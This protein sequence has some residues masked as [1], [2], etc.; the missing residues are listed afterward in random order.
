MQSLKLQKNKNFDNFITEK[1][2]KKSPSYQDDVL[3]T[4][5]RLDE[6][7]ILTHER[8]RDDIIDYLRAMQSIEE[9]EEETIGW[10]QGFIDKIGEGGKISFKVLQV[11][12]SHIKKYLKYF[13]IRVDFGDEIELPTALLEE[14]YAIPI[15]D[16][17]TI[18]ENSPWKYKGYFLSLVSS[19]ARPIEIMAL[20]KKDFVWMNTRW[21]AIIP[22]KYTKKKISRT[23]FFSIEVTPYINK[24]LR[25][26]QDD[27]RIWP[28][29]S[30]L[31]DDKLTQARQNAGVMFRKICNK[32]GFTERYETTNFFKYNLYCFRSHFFTKALRALSE[33]K[34]TAHAMIGHGAYLQNYQRRTDEEKLELFEEVESE[35]LIFDQT[36]NKE[37][38][39]KLKEANIK[40]EEKVNTINELR[41]DVEQLKAQKKGI[42]KRSNMTTISESELSES[43][44]K[45]LKEEQ[46]KIVLKQ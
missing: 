8:R 46:S 7:T 1:L 43:A 2:S 34:D 36:K 15:D 6:Y 22:A 28:K 18:I 31:D 24:L 33:D 10:I 23:V 38:I 44:R 29:N 13:K 9:R 26:V 30:K 39:L 17:R 42:L 41:I 21:K 16:I 37:K 20:R 11:Y 35:I 19:G 25:N 14:R 5:R 12:L 4:L 45:V 27:D 32:L 40:L 3:R